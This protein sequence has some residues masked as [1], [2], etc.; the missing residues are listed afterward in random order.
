VGSEG[1][2]KSPVRS[3]KSDAGHP[4]GGGIRLSSFLLPKGYLG[5]VKLSAH[6]EIRPGVKRPVAWACEQP[7]N[8]DGSITTTLKSDSDPGWRKGV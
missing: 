8:A 1:P 6:L 2:E 3:A 7:V 4:Q 5:D